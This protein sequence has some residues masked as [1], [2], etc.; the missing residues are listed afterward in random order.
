MLTLLL[1]HM[2]EASGEACLG[3]AGQSGCS[4]WG[5]MGRGMMGSGMMNWGPWGNWGLL[6]VWGLWL[7]TWGLGILVLIALFRW[8]WKR[9]ER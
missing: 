6:G 7:V 3:V 2:G 1:A 5:I 8:L 4:S 9:G